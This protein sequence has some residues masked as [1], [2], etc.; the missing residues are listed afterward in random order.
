MFAHPV[1]HLVNKHAPCGTLK[2]RPWGPMINKSW[3]P[4]R[5][6]KEKQKRKQVIK[7]NNV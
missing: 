4:F 5:Q 3:P 7:I 1:A 6:F 2:A